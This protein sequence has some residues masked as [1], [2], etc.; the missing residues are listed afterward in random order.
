[1]SQEVI[2]Q[3][4]QNT[5]HECKQ[6]YLDELVMVEIDEY[7]YYNRKVETDPNAKIRM[8][9]MC[10]DRLLIFDEKVYIHGYMNGRHLQ[11]PIDL[12]DITWRLWQESDLKL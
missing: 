5:F 10:V 7:G 1:M 11:L 2:Q 6:K 8:Y 4:L 9:P 3:D 12:Y